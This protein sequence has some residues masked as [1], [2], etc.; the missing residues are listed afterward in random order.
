MNTR[1][2]TQGGAAANVVPILTV[3]ALAGATMFFFM[4]DLL[5]KIRKTTNIGGDKP[6]ANP[7]ADG[8]SSR[9]LFDE[10]GDE[11]LADEA[12]YGVLGDED[13]QGAV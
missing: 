8:A 2:S 12:G 3:L 13:N 1:Y 7:P 10:D 5:A 4:P 11:V 9:R 6:P